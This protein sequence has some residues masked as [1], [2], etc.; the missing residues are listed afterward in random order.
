MKYIP[1]KKDK[2]GKWMENC[3][4]TRINKE[5]RARKEKNRKKPGEMK[6]G[7][8]RKQETA[9]KT[10]NILKTLILKGENNLCFNLY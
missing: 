2:Y 8:A 7:R 4:K 1:S 9:K 10:Q 6:R 5:A 3:E